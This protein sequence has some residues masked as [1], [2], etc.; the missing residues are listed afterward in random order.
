MSMYTT[1]TRNMRTEKA[2]VVVIPAK[3]ASGMVKT[4]RNGTTSPWTGL[5]RGILLAPMGS[6]SFLQGWGFRSVPVGYLVDRMH[7]GTRGIQT[8]G[9]T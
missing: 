3:M 1:A 9:I 2:K 8:A 4:Q 5:R 7:C 6:F